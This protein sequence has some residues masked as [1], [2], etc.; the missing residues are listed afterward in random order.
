MIAQSVDET[1]KTELQTPSFLKVTQDFSVRFGIDNLENISHLLY[2][3]NRLASQTDESL[4]VYAN[5]SLISSQF[6]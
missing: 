1:I 4:R 3:S 2:V 5:V 6:I